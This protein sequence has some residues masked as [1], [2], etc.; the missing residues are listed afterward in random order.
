MHPITKKDKDTMSGLISVN[1]TNILNTR[2]DGLGLR[3]VF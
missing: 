2:N 1:Q 3:C